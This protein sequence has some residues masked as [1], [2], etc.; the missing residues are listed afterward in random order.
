[1]VV[2]G[3]IHMPANFNKHTCTSGHYIDRLNLNLSMPML[4]MN[5]RGIRLGHNLHPNTM[6]YLYKLT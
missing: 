6:L 4:G 2:F 1:M 3:V 5:S